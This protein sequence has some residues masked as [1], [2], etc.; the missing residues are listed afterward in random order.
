MKVFVARRALAAA[1]SCILAA[2]PPV[3]TAAP[4]ASVSPSTRV[5]PKPAPVAK[6]PPAGRLAASLPDSVLGRV[7]LGPG[8]KQVKD[9]TERAVFSAAAR[10]GRRIDSLTP[11][12]RRQFLDVLVD[13]AVLVDR[14]HQEPRRWDH[15][16][17]SDWNALRD[18]LMLRAALDS[19]MIEMNFARAGRGDSLLGQQQLGLALRDSAMARLAP[20]WHE[21]ELDK[22]ASL[23]DTL[24]RPNAGMSVLEQMRVAGLKPQ[25]G[26]GDSLRVLVES[27]AGRYTL[28]ELV[29]DYGRLNP[30]YRPRISTRDHVRELASNV[31]YENLLRQA[32][33]ERHFDRR[34]NVAHALAERAEYLDVSRYVAREVYAK[35]AMDSVTIRKHYLAHVSRWDF[36]ER[37]R[38][39]RMT[40]P[41]RADAEAMVR[42]LTV[43]LEAESL[44]AQSARAGVPYA[45]VVAQESDTLLFG[46]I[47]RAGVGGVLG[48]D[49]TSQGWR[50]LRVMALEPKRRRTFEQAFEMVRSDWYDLEGERLM[51]SVLDGLRRH[52]LVV[53]NERALRG[54]GAGT[55]RKTQR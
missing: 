9:I 41:Q 18:R 20:K 36:D 33:E 49:S 5:A 39:L 21:A 31:L 22:A 52:V 44:E 29:T 14:V 30:M 23:F 24:P 54:P 13:Q 11:Q 10:A 51:R 6:A 4:A 47:R 43:P 46:R 48:P 3:A 1:L 19:A 37:A 15:R 2:L 42:R 55:P 16:D 8:A 25:L 12:D 45:T 38:V 7:F 26:P 17:S 34:P 35:I 28:G 53:P 50:A 32:A 27:A 40:F